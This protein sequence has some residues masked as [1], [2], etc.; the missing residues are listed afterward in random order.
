MERSSIFRS[1][2]SWSTTCQNLQMYFVDYSDKKLQKCK[3]TLPKVCQTSFE[4]S[5]CS[6]E[7]RILERDFI[8]TAPFWGSRIFIVSEGKNFFSSEKRQKWLHYFVRNKETSSETIKSRRR[9]RC[10]SRFS[11]D[12]NFRCIC[13]HILWSTKPFMRFHFSTFDIWKRQIWKVHDPL[14]LFISVRYVILLITFL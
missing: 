10:L 12:T 7:K 8:D 4:S 11:V 13:F 6:D 5:I 3:Q 9:I 14:G 1:L 2:H